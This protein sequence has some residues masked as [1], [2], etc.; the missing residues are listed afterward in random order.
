MYLDYKTAVS[1][2]NCK[3]MQITNKPSVFFKVSKYIRMSGFSKYSIVYYSDSHV[4]RF[5][6]VKNSFL[7]NFERQ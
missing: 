1:M 2:K 6:N 7:D 4:H 3:I 5:K